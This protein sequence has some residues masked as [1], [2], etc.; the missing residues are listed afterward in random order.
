MKNINLVEDWRS[1]WKWFSSWMFLLVMFL[2]AEPLPPELMAVLP[3]RAQNVL[4]VIA[5]VAGLLLRFVKQSKGGIDR[6]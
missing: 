5:A 3:E 6:G 1:G 2:A 4:I